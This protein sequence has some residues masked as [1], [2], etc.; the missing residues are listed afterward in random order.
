MPDEQDQAQAEEREESDAK[1]L[2]QGYVNRHLCDRA[3]NAVFYTP[4][5]TLSNF[6]SRAV[7]LGLSEAE[8]RYGGHFPQRPEKHKRLP[9]GPRAG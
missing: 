2:L 8:G 1:E 3:R 5:L 4:G 9:P 6:L 7:E